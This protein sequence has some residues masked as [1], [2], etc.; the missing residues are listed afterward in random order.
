[1][2]AQRLST[3][4]NFDVIFDLLGRDRLMARVALGAG[5]IPG[6]YSFRNEYGQQAIFNLLSDLCP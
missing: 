6:N 2:K 3:S 5:A 1:M 4:P